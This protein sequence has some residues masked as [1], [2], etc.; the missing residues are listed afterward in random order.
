MNYD[1][2]VKKNFN[3]IKFEFYHIKNNLLVKN[4]ANTN[5]VKYK[6]IITSYGS[7]LSWNL[8]EDMEGYDIHFMYI[9]M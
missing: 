7:L 6:N 8:S 9:I 2:A 5:F 4:S 3:R 1:A